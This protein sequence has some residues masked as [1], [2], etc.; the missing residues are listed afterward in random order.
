MKKE[1][2]CSKIDGFWFDSIF[3]YQGANKNHE[4]IIIDDV[5]TTR[6]TEYIK[7][8]KIDKV[9]IDMW[10]SNIESLEFV[11]EIK[12]IKFLKVKGQIDINYSPL[13]K[14]SNLRYIEILAPN[15]FDVSKFKNL[16]FLSTNRPSGIKGINDVKKLTTLKLLDTYHEF[17]LTDLSFL[18]SNKS[19]EVLELRLSSIKSLNGLNPHSKLRSLSLEFM[20]GLKDITDLKCFSNNLTRLLIYKCNN[21]QELNII[22]SLRELEY[23]HISDMKSIDSIK[24]LSN[25]NKLKTCKLSNSLI[26]D[27]DLTPLKGLSSVVVL[28]MKRHYHFKNNDKIEKPYF[29]IEH[30]TGMHDGYSGIPLWKR[31]Y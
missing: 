7:K 5:D 31:I 15:D 30:Y 18:K 29:R 16:E 24:Y 28:P 3:M 17:H 12:D 26:I 11:S 10:D 27:G 13:Y 4:A 23:L 19:I 2:V 1:L 9:I 20:N 21:I 14:L 25:N 6:F 8:N 22:G